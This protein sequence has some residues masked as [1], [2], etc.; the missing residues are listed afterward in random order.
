MNYYD[1]ILCVIISIPFV[2]GIYTAI[3]LRQK[4]KKLQRK[5]TQLIIRLLELINNIQERIK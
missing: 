2:F 3:L 5:D 1:L 4:Q